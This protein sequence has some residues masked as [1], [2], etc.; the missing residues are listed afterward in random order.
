MGRRKDERPEKLAEKL[1]RIRLKLG[2]SQA[3]MTEALEGYGVKLH[4][5]YISFYENDVRVPPLLVTLAY[6]RLA[7][8]RSDVLIDDKRNLPKGF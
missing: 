2:L 4:R 7:K 5:G 6:A 1:L 3:K 8:V